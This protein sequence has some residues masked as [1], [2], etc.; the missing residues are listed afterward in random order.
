MPKEM[1]DAAAMPPC[2][3]VE[4][5]VLEGNGPA[6]WQPDPAFGWFERERRLDPTPA[7]M[8]EVQSLWRALP[9]GM[10]ARCHDPSFGLRFAD[11]ERTVLEARIC[12]RCRNASLTDGEAK[13]WL[14]FDARSAQAVRLR[15]LLVDIAERAGVVLEDADELEDTE[16]SERR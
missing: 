15:A 1:Y 2:D 4:V 11:G 14:K 10:Q 6:W 8:R 16:D 13:G 12:F 3:R 7:E 9:D 5:F